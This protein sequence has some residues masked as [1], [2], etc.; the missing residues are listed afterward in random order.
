MVQVPNVAT[1]PTLMTVAEARR[2]L[3]ALGFQVKLSPPNKAPNENKAYV[4]AQSIPAGQLAPKG[5][6]ITLKL[7]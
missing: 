7:H 1:V 4:D 3:E 5:S 6:T 2:Q